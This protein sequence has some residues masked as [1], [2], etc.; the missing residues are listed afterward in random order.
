MTLIEQLKSAGK[1]SREL[2]REIDRI[3]NPPDKGWLGRYFPPHPYTTSLDA[4]LKLVPAKSFPEIKCD[5]VGWRAVIWP[6][7]GPHWAADAPT[8]AL[9]LCIAALKARQAMEEAAVKEFT[10]PRIMCGTVCEVWRAMI[11]R[12][13]DGGS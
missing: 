10:V 9:A 13:R 1:G 5:R 3:A 11:Q 12:I 6:H 8:A 2:D 7:F 4:A